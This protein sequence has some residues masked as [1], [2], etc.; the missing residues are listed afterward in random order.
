ML[1]V[2]DPYEAY[3]VDQAVLLYCATVEDILEKVPTPK[4]KHASER[5]KARQD[6]LLQKILQ[7]EKKP[8]KKFRDPADML[9]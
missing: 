3:C 9:K 4:G 2:E 8:E 6:D 1:G 7:I 5:R